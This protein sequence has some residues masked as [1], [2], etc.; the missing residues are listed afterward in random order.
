MFKIDF[1][2]S[3]NAL[4]KDGQVV[5]KNSIFVCDCDVDNE[6]GLTDRTEKSS[7]LRV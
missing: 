4:Y 3:Q 7:L 1:S 6:S 2:P 5:S